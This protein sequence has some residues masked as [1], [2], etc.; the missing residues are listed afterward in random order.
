MRTR[1][2]SVTVLVRE[3]LQNAQTNY[4]TPNECTKSEIV[5]IFN[6]LTN[7][8]HLIMKRIL[9]SLICVC[10]TLASFTQVP[11]KIDRGVVAL[12]VD[13]NSVYVGW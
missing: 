12:T 2:V 7:Q 9:T 13:R 3:L 8:D 5:R 6:V 1:I 4:T 10:L 11:E